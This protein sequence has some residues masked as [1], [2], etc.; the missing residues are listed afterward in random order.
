MTR[1]FGSPYMISQG[2]VYKLQRETGVFS[3]DLLQD[4]IF[5]HHHILPIHEIEGAFGPLI[6]VCRELPTKVGPVDIAFI[7]ANGLLTLVECKLWK[8]P[9][10]RREVVGQILDY[11]KE[12]SQWSYENLESAIRRAKKPTVESLYQWVASQAEEVDERDFIDSV[13]QNLRRGRFLLLIT[14]DGIRENM[15][16]MAEFLERYAH[17]NFSFALLE[18]G[19]YQL[20]VDEGYFVQPRL[21]THTV[22][23]VRAVV[24]IENDQ[25]VVMPEEEKPSRLAKRR[26][27]ISEQVFFEELNAEPSIKLQ[28]KKFF[29]QVENMGMFVQPGDDSMIIKSDIPQWNFGIF[30]RR[31][32]FYNRGIA[33]SAEEAGHPELGAEYLHGLAGLLTNGYVLK[34]KGPFQRTVKIKD[35]KKDRY[36]TIAELMAIQDPWLALIEKTLNQMASI[37]TE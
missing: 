12:I 29:E 32:D 6:P 36:A 27:K 25:I 37:E 31:G 14:G 21:L 20:P 16:Q 17:L 1:Q 23:S 5:N 26:E 18:V 28:L 22:E 4:F 10:A 33:S 34:G 11:A 3:E 15:E 13:S 19:I 2:T 8:N 35:G 7:N 30:T 9:E 24:K